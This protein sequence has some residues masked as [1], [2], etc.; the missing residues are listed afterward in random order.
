MSKIFL[1]LSLTSIM[2][3]LGFSEKNESSPPQLVRVDCGQLFDSVG[4]KVVFSKSLYILN[5]KILEIVSNFGE[6][7]AGGT[8]TSVHNLKDKLCAPGLIDTHVHFET[9]FPDLTFF[10]HPDEARL[11]IESIDFPR[12]TL[13]A[14][15]TTV[16]DLYSPRNLALNFRNAI[17]S[18]KMVGPR[19]LASGI[20]VLTAPGGHGDSS[21]RIKEDNRLGAKG[22]YKKYYG[23]KYI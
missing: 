4:G 6:P 1:L 11:V 12:R 9:T 5:G 17:Q 19:I 13:E 3:A 2:G 23:L 18:G 15:F 7:A 21:S 22:L 10:S 14:G 20:A 8:V 16:R